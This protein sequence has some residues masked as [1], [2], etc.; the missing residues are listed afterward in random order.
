[1]RRQA[2]KFNFF[3]MSTSGNELHNEVWYQICEMVMLFDYVRLRSSSN[4][5]RCLDPVPTLSYKSYKI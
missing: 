5:M 3:Y 2:M 4:R 1:M